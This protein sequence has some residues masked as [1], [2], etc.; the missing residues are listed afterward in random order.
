MSTVLDQVSIR[1]NCINSLCNVDLFFRHRRITSVQG[2]GLI[3]SLATGS[4]KDAMASGASLV[5]PLVETIMVTPV[6]AHSLSFRPALV[7]IW[8][9]LELKLSD[10]ARSSMRVELDTSQQVQL[11]KG[12]LFKIVVSEFPISFFDL[13][14]YNKKSDWFGF[15]RENMHWNYVTKNK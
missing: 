6:C 14:E 5:H 11:E 12:N 1:N 2:D 7:P 15:L 3:I 4:T 9:Q 10:R 13:P 8:A